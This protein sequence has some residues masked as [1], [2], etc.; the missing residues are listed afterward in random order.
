MPRATCVS[1]TRS[2]VVILWE[3]VHNCDASWETVDRFPSVER[4]PNHAL[5]KIRGY[6]AQRDFRVQISLGLYTAVLSATR[7]KLLMLTMAIIILLN[8]S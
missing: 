8:S 1:D 6:E 7:L 5:Q 4:L 2:S 3:P